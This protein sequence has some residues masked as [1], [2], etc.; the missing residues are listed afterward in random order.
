[1]LQIKDRRKVTHA[2]YPYKSSLTLFSSSTGSGN[3]ES[4]LQIEGGAWCFFNEVNLIFSYVAL[5][6]R[7]ESRRAF[8]EGERGSLRLY[9]RRFPPPAVLLFLLLVLSGLMLPRLLV[10]AGLVV[11]STDPNDES[12][13]SQDVA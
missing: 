2:T 11:L 3:N 6:F 1:M 8:S 9:L 4:K 12:I 13:V 10:D 7:R 5:R